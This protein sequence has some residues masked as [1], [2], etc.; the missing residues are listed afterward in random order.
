MEELEP[1]SASDELGGGQLRA[2]RFLGVH[3]DGSVDVKTVNMRGFEVGTEVNLKIDGS[4]KTVEIVPISK[5]KDMPDDGDV[6]LCR[7]AQINK[8]DPMTTQY[9][10]RVNDDTTKEGYEQ[11]LTSAPRA[12]LI[13]R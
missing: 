7:V 1:T 11:K 2:L 12:V 5:I 8:Y 4:D 13:Q 9:G 6:V 3:A 10:T